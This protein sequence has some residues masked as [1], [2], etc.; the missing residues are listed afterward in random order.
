MPSVSFVQ[1]CRGRVDRTL[2]ALFIGL[3]LSLG[4]LQALA[5]PAGASP[6]LVPILDLL[7]NEQSDGAVPQTGQTIILDAVRVG[8]DLQVAKTL[9]F[10]NIP[11]APV[12]VHLTLPSGA[13]VSMSRDPAVEGSE[14]LIFSGVTDSV[15]GTVYFQGIETGQ[16]TLTVQAAG[17]DTLNT[18][19]EVVPSSFF[20]ETPSFSANQKTVLVNPNGLPQITIR[21]AA[22]NVSGSV[23][24][25]QPLRANLSVAF[26]VVSSNR[27]IGTVSNVYNNLYSIDTRLFVAS[28]QDSVNALFW[29]L[30]TGATELSIQQPEGFS[31]MNTASPTTATV[32]A[33][34]PSS[35]ARFVMGCE[36][37][38]G[39]IGT[40]ILDVQGFARHGHYLWRR[41]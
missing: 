17:Y 24:E 37:N 8:K 19:L 32:N 1:C 18:S 11:S 9:R 35:K 30:S 33:S 40:L 15:I 3:F 27:A 25:I 22:L 10:A 2:L 21:S 5:A 28:N 38:A 12:D 26:N 16:E 7:L 6:V 14:T 41:A 34:A 13:T 23:L 39:V 36:L 29:P 20:I 4:A 31:A